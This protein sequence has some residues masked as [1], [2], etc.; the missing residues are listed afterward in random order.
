MKYPYILRKMAS[1]APRDTI[2]RAELDNLLITNLAS[3]MAAKLT[4]QSNLEL[5]G[6]K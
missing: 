5:T 2:E 3:K 4:F 1:T 6:Y